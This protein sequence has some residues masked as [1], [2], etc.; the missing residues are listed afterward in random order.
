M[1]TEA[2]PKNMSA[3]HIGC[4][5]D[6]S[7][8]SAQKTSREQFEGKKA[9]EQAANGDWHVYSF[10]EAKSILRSSH[11]KQAGFQAEEME[12]MPKTLR[13]PI[14]FQEGQS[15]R[16]Q[17]TK[18]ARFFTPLT[19]DKNYREF[20][21]Q[22]SDRALEP[23]SNSGRADLSDLSMSLA[24]DVAAQVIGLTNSRVGGMSKRLE[25]FF[26][27]SGATDGLERNVF[28]QFIHFVQSQFQ[29][30]KFFFLDVQPAIAA[31]KKEA[32]ED[33]VSHL[34][35]EDYKA[36]EILTE[37][38][39]FAAAGMVTTREFIS[40]CAW[41]FF[42][43][44]ELKAQY[45]AAEQ[46]E[47]YKILHELLRLEPVVGQLYRRATTDFNV[48]V[49]GT[50]H[51]I[52]EG[53]RIILHIYAT[54]TDETVVG[55]EAERACPVRSFPRGVDDAVMGFGDGHHRCPGAYIAIQETD[56]F[57][58]KLF[59][60]KSLKMTQKP[61]LAWSEVVKGYELRRFMIEV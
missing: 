4:P 35:S 10:A 41:H 1:T 28:A 44:A 13:D 26:E 15:H 29:V 49:D 55:E 9:I 34:I 42:E 22:F 21:E 45:L 5:I 47:R 37:C 7:K 40:L 20:M 25:A 6:H 14:L 38:I 58:K 3:P 33:L 60:F 36:I 8:L 56:I 2:T 23:L 54:N 24:V 30:A 61:D 59:A 52:R 18:T 31:R 50:S 48:E 27:I 39:T 16:E 57:L 12:K 46:A 11:T 19:T 53:E 51:D 43:N 32:R 17:R